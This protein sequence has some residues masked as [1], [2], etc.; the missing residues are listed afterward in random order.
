M[1]LSPLSY[2]CA[3]G[4][5]LLE[6]AYVF[7]SRVADEQMKPYTDR[8]G[9]MIYPPVLIWDGAE[10]MQ[11]RLCEL[12]REV[13]STRGMT[14]EADA[15]IPLATEERARLAGLSFLSGTANATSA[16]I[17]QV[18]SGM[19]TGW[20]AARETPAHDWFFTSLGQQLPIRYR[21]MSRHGFYADVAAYLGSMGEWIS[22]DVVVL[23]TSWHEPS[24]EEMNAMR[25][26]LKSSC[27]FCV[28][29]DTNRLAAYGA[30]QIARL[31]YYG[32]R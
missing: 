11:M 1:T 13:L 8:N 19:M 4:M 2:T 25:R 3:P 6:C 17:L 20:I 24:A 18:E 23:D 12:A 30:A 15:E 31:A 26:S 27:V 16:V 9:R 7:L 10:D 21:D 5:T 28:M 14:L 32:V 29:A 22:P